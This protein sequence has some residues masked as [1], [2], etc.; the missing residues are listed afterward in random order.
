MAAFGM[1]LSQATR[2]AFS[3]SA[4]PTVLNGTPASWNQPW[5]NPEASSSSIGITHRLNEAVTLGVTAGTLNESHSILGTSYDAGSSLS[6]GAANT[7]RSLGFSAALSLD[8]SNSVLF[9]VGTATT[10]GASADSLFAGTTDIVSRSYGVTF[11]SRNLVR[12]NDRLMLSVKQPLRVVSGQAGVIVPAIDE[13]GIAHF[14][15]EWASL[16]PNGREVHYAMSFDTPISRTQ[17]FAHSLSLQA[18]YRK[19]LFNIS[20]SKDVSVGAVWTSRF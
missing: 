3:W 4:T 11:M 15:T 12:T 8:A 16:V 17:S 5:T 18:G 7:S 1:P 9:E 20:G 6:L 19:D 13:Q 2:V 14:N 10:K